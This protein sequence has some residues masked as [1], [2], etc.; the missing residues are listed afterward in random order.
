SIKIIASFSKLSPTT[1]T[2]RRD[3]VEQQIPTNELV[4]GDIILI[5]TGD[6]LPADCRFLTCEGLK[7]N[8]AELTGETKPITVTVHCTGQILMESTNIGFYSSFVE[9][10][11]GE[12]IVIATG[13]NTILGKMSGTTTKDSSGD[14]ITNL[15]REVNR[16][17]L[18]A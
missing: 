11:M 8:S 4:P 13:D 14:E 17:V 5:Q 6:V 12:A 7:V 16:F 9:Q 15:H 2:V 3:G 1:A 18:M 10:G